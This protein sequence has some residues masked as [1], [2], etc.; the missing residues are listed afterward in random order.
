[1]GFECSALSR[2]GVEELSKCFRRARRKVFWDLTPPVG[3]GTISP[4]IQGP[5]V[6]ARNAHTC[7]TVPAEP[8]LFV[9]GSESPVRIMMSR[10]PS[11]TS[12]RIS[13]KSG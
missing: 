3:R 7:R 9:A 11:E 2:N 4:I 8:D 5:E 6:N 1:M 10:W 13:G 12:C